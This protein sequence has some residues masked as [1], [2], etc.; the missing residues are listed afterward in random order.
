MMKK[1]IIL[2]RDGVINMDSP[3]FIK[4]E[5]E[6]QPIPGSLEAIATLNKHGF[7]VFVTT[8]QSG[9][10]R[11]LLDLQTLNRIHQK[12]INALAL[13][14]GKI[15]GIYFCPHGP[16]DDCFCRKPLP[17]MFQQIAK[18]YNID[19]NQQ[20][21]PAIGDSLRDLEAAV[22]AH[23]EPILVLT[24]NGKKTAKQLN[25]IAIDEPKAPGLLETSPTIATPISPLA[26][27]RVRIFP[28]LN[29]AVLDIIQ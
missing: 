20:K 1:V 17:G 21:V 18:D 2:D 6:W 11:G 22:L 12:M 3:N 16:D 24:G 4:S 23:C 19:F 26:T 14:G 28:S 8:N 29:A 13:V 9:I 10:A 27:K 25:Q 5:E 7:T 15:E